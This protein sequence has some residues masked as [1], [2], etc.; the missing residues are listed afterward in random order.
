MRH[1]VEIEMDLQ[2]RSGGNFCGPTAQPADYPTTWDVESLWE[3]SLM[4]GIGFND[5]PEGEDIY[6]TMMLSS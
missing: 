5:P 2:A 6:D 4:V 1:E 3:A